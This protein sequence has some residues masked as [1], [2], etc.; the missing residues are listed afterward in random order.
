MN[1]FLKTFGEKT[2]AQKIIFIIIFIAIILV[3]LLI[4]IYA[5]GSLAISVTHIN[6]MIFNRPFVRENPLKVALTS[7]LGRLLCLFV[8][9]TLIIVFAMI[10]SRLNKKNYADKADKRGVSFMQKA[11]FGSSRW[12]KGKEIAEHFTV[13][14]I[15]NTTETIYGQLTDEGEKV[16]GYKKVEKGGSGNHNLLMI[17]TAGSGKSFCYVR[18]EILQASRR[19]NSIVVTDPKGELYKDMA[20]YLESTGME[21][22]VLNMK[23]PQLSDSWNI[24]EE[25]INPDTDRLDGAR[26]NSFTSIFM[27]NSSGQQNK[28]YWYY[29]AFNLICTVIG[30]T[31]HNHERILA[32][33]YSYLLKDVDI[34]REI[35]SKYYEKIT[36]TMLSFKEVKE[37]IKNIA[38]KNGF[39]EE[40]INNK[41]KSIKNKANRLAPY[42]IA[43]VIKN[44]SMIESKNVSENLEQLPKW[45]PAYMYYKTYK[46][47]DTEQVRKS[48]IQGSLLRFMDISDETMKM[49]LSTSGIHLSEGIN[50]KPTAIF[51]ITDDTAEGVKTKPIISLFFSFLF[52]D[53]IKV[54]DDTEAKVEYGGENDCIPVSVIL[55][56]AFSLGVI[57]GTSEGFAQ[58]LS[59][60]RSRKIWISIICQTYTQIKALYGDNIGDVI[61]GNCKT[62]LY[63]GGNDPSTLDFISK[64]SGEST[65]LRE[66]HEEYDNL[67]F[68]DEIKD[69]I[70][71]TA[72]RRNLVTT[73][74]GREW[75]N[76]VLVI[77]QGS[78]PLE[79]KPFGWNQHPLYEEC[80]KHAVSL[81]TK[82]GSSTSVF[83]KYYKP[84]NLSIDD[85][86][87]LVNNTTGEKINDEIEIIELDE[88]EI[89]NQEEKIKEVIKEKDTDSSKQDEEKQESKPQT[90]TKEAKNTKKGKAK[91][92]KKEKE[93]LTS[94]EDD[95]LTS[96]DDEFGDVEEMP[97]GKKANSFENNEKKSNQ[98]V[99]E[100]LD[101]ASLLQDFEKENKE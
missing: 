15:K 75:A 70:K 71:S 19:G 74:E 14:N 43:M 65:V 4:G 13:D 59:T 81:Y 27:A 95:G 37:V 60:A 50:K 44:L 80:L 2:L 18:N 92:A 31:S 62:L 1:R 66:S 93:V 47:N 34:N 24:L 28:E 79:L 16:V 20:G 78:K 12:L 35:N 84:K 57:T 40:T 56:E 77:N 33:E 86:G 58:V 39:D 97:K 61:Q 30:Y 38:T 49:R 29:S 82:Y 21:V 46:T 88:D 45:H 55:D 51:V 17:A 90:Q 25:T 101:F 98:I 52:T 42:T 99:E 3:L 72:D 54:Y 53:L 9:A 7:S 32:N 22:K 36:S 6:D 73:G 89:L 48:A 63:L 23:N 96:F 11:T 69:T 94:I 41:L 26:L 5:A 8:F 83:S 100:T 64:F 67:F 68:S 91:K 85:E 10:F 76:Q 87:N